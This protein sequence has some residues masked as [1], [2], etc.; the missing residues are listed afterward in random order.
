MC[1]RC[2]VLLFML[3]GMAVLPFVYLISFAFEV[4]A[5]GYVAVVLINIVTGKSLPRCVTQ[6]IRPVSVAAHVV[7]LQR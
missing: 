6:A 7:V 4:S 3:Y 5:S 1:D 2:C